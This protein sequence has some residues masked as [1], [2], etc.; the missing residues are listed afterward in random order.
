MADKVDNNK[1]PNGI[2]H[3]NTIHQT[4]IQL[5]GQNKIRGKKENEVRNAPHNSTNGPRSREP[6][7]E[8]P[9]LP[10][11]ET[12]HSS[13]RLSGLPTLLVAL[14]LVRRWSR[15]RHFAL[16]SLPFSDGLLKFK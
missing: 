16:H 14:S 3:E 4:I 10:S 7:E 9:V 2:C 11:P 15:D 1:Q 6:S 12:Y 5:Y 13:G 8:R